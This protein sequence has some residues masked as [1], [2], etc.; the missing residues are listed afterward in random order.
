MSKFVACITRFDPSSGS[1]ETLFKAKSKS[2]KISRW[3]RNQE[4]ME[5]RMAEAVQV[6]G[7]E[8]LKRH[9]RSNSKD[10]NG[11]MKER[12]V[13]MMHANRKALKRLLK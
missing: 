3:L 11:F 9:K 7:E 13:N 5:R 1:V 8:F 10:Q 4:R 6:F 12:G 2:K